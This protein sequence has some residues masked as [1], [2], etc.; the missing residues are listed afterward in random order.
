M[1]ELWEK[2]LGRPVVLKVYEDNQGTID[3]VKAGYS[4]AL[5]HLSKTQKIS[6]DL[7]HDIRTDLQL[8]ELNKIDGDQQAADIFTKALEPAKWQNAIDM[9]HMCT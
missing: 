1:Q 4:P 3:V 8:A 2:L 9:L 5:R 7:V 6:I